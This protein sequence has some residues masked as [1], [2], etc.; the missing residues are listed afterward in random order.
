MQRIDH[1]IL[2]LALCLIAVLLSAGCT[3]S[4]TSNQTNTKSN[5][6]LSSAKEMGNESSWM[7]VPITDVMTGRQ[8]TIVD[9][10]DEGKP[11]IIHS[12]AVWCPACSIQLRETAK[13]LK[14]NPG[15]YT[16]LGIDFDSRENTEMIKSHVEKNQFVGMYIAAPT[17]LTRGLI[18]T[19]GP[20]VVQSLPQTLI[21]CNKKVTYVGD[22][23][24]PEA[25]LKSILSELC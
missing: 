1:R 5:T 12:F 11:V 19:V 21:I 10:A 20:R 15:A 3:T 8:T 25:K 7:T 6:S 16:V 22:G 18:Q 14:E 2:L 13:L 24:F 23:A 9:L 4:D 17:D